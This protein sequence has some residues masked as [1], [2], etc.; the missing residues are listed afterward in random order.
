MVARLLRKILSLDQFIVK[1]GSSLDSMLH[2]FQAHTGAVR[3]VSFSP[4]GQQ[5]LTASEDKSVKLWTVN[6]PRYLLSIEVVV[7]M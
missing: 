7:S 6:K 3:H 4:D 5:L 1:L 2:Y